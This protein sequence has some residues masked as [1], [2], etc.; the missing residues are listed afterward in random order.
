[1]INKNL[2]LIVNNLSF[3]ISHRLS[4]SIFLSQN[5]YKITILTNVDDLSLLKKNKLIL[6]K[7]KIRIVNFPLNR[8]S[9]NLLN[10]YKTI[11][12][13]NNTINNFDINYVVS[14]SPMIVLQTI[15]ASLTIFKKNICFFHT[16]SGYGKIGHSN[17]IF[18]KSIFNFFKLILKFIILFPTQYLIVQ[19][20][21]IYNSI[22]K[23]SKKIFLIHGLGINTSKYNYK[24]IPF[25]NSKNSNIS[26]LLPARVIKDKGIREFFYASLN[27]IKYYKN[28]K[29]LVAGYVD[30]ASNNFLKKSEIEFFQSYNH[31]IFLGNVSDMVNL[32]NKVH[33]VCLPSYH[34]GFSR[35][36]SEAASTGK[37]LI[38]SDISGCNE[39]VIDGFNGFL[40]KPK[41]IK[42]LSEAI[43]KIIEFKNKDTMSQNSR[44]IIINNFS[45]KIIFKKY[46]NMLNDQ[47]SEVI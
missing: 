1:M 6:D 10:I 12:K 34:E 46:L 23:E 24:F 25:K 20:T 22:S 15:F 26:I 8:N 11:K 42:S 37:L 32:Y 30:I 19:N 5:D 44:S 29:F 45:E 28:V 36:L 27:V 13:I 47:N 35:S 41:N 2:L 9:L 14:V 16:I 38:A 31:F 21:N 40:C 43:I 4:I 18:A 7:Y 39:I 3:F 17:N 33:V